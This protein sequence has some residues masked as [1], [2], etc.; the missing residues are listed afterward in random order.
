[1]PAASSAAI[2]VKIITVADGR[3][4]RDVPRVNGA[5]ILFDTDDLS[6]RESSTR[7]PS[8]PTGLPQCLQRLPTSWPWRIPAF[9]SYSAPGRRLAGTL[10]AMTSIHEISLICIAERC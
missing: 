8:L 6:V 2:G 10:P 1:M 3:P 4:P 9:L 5:Y 7:H